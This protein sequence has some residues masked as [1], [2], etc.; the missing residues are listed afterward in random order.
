MKQLNNFLEYYLNKLYD[1][2]NKWYQKILA[3]IDYWNVRNE[4]K[5]GGTIRF[6]V[7]INDKKF[8]SSDEGAIKR[9]LRNEIYN[10]EGKYACE[11]IRQSDVKFGYVNDDFLKNIMSAKVDV[12]FILIEKL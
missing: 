6:C 12:Q 7:K 4:I 2:L 1:Y 9:A 3:K 8:D 10:F 5:N 11:V